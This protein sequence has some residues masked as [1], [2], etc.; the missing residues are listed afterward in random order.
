MAR[1]HDGL[2]GLAGADVP[3]LDASEAPVIKTVL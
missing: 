1:D 2:A 3:R